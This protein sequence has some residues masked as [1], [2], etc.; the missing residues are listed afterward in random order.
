MSLASPV[1]GRVAVWILHTP[2]GGLVMGMIPLG[3]DNSR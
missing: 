1:T 2:E 3:D